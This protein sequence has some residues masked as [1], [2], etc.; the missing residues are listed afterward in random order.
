MVTCVSFSP[1]NMSNS[2]VSDSTPPATAKK[3]LVVDD[4]TDVT[5]LLSYT[6]KA[7]GYTVEALNDPNR[8]VGFARTFCRIWWCWM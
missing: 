7:K 6:L 3:I 2:I 8:S 1:Y 4:E 5:E